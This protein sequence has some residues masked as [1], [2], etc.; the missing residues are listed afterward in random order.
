MTDNVSPYITTA[1]LAQHLR[2]TPQAISIA[3]REGRFPVR[4]VRTSAGKTA[5]MRFLQSQVAAAFR[6]IAAVEGGTGTGTEWAQ[7]C[8]RQTAG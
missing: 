1:E 8:H 2:C 7:G 5:G 6:G 4:P 3:V